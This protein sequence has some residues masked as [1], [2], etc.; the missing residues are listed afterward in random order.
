M[1]RSLFCSFW[2]KVVLRI[3]KNRFPAIWTRIF[4]DAQNPF[5]LKWTKQRPN[6][7]KEFQKKT[8]TH[9]SF[10]SPSYHCIYEKNCIF[11]W[12]LS[13]FYF[14][15]YSDEGVFDVFLWFCSVFFLKILYWMFNHFFHFFKTPIIDL[16][17]FSK[18]FVGLN[19]TTLFKNTIPKIKVQTRGKCSL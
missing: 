7:N 11:L 19:L 17:L 12:F 18:T 3:D 13:L 5:F 8:H 2:E 1:F 16:W 9:T 6:T 15:R 10:L 4:I 14:Y